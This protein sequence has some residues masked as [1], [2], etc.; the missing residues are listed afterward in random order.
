MPNFF[1]EKKKSEA[2]AELEKK[3][4]QRDE[5]IEA[6]TKD[7]TNLETEKDAIIKDLNERLKFYEDAVS[8][9]D[10]VDMD[11]WDGE[12]EAD[13]HRE[14]AEFTDAEDS[15]DEVEQE[16]TFTGRNSNE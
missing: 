4:E 15:E 11:D 6:L 14:F 16:V 1:V 3:L 7:M 13:L 9:D 5:L 12:E 10:D 8:D 2:V